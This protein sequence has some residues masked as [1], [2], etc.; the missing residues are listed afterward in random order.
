M[1]AAV[2]VLFG[3]LTKTIL[4]AVILILYVGQNLT[5]IPMLPMY[6]GLLPNHFWIVMLIS[7]LLAALLLW[8]SAAL[9]RRTQ[10]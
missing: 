4:L 1:S 6:F 5:L 2:G 7:G 9:F 3:V 8:A 10:Y